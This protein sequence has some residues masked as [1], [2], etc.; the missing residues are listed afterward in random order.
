LLE[1]LWELV[2][3]LGIVAAAAAATHQPETNTIPKNSYNRI[4]LL[5]LLLRSERQRQRQI[6]R[7]FGCCLFQPRDY[8]LGFAWGFFFLCNLAFL[9][10]DGGKS[11]DCAVGWHHHARI[12]FFFFFFFFFTI[13]TTTIA[14]CS[15]S[16]GER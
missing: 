2:V 3:A 10:G 9:F 12:A 11:C 8:N 5:L 6:Q 4:L 1:E 16:S 14:I 13:T 15:S 7:G